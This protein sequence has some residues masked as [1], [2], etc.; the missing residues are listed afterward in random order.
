MSDLQGSIKV[1]LFVCYL[2]VW[3]CLSLSIYSFIHSSYNLSILRRGSSDKNS[4][5][6]TSAVKP[7]MELHSAEAVIDIKPDMDDDL[8]AEVHAETSITSGR[9]T[10]S[11]SGRSTAELHR[12][13]VPPG[14]SSRSFGRS[15]EGYRSTEERLSSA[16]GRSSRSSGSS[17]RA[18]VHRD[19]PEYF[20][21][22]YYTF[23]HNSHFYH[24]SSFFFVL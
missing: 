18:Q 16:Y 14:A 2:F 21:W 6:L 15:T 22:P 12:S 24:K 5:R 8:I 17:S 11:T 23:N 20:L 3:L 19:P 10:R 1:Y 13:R 4:S 9:P 7:L